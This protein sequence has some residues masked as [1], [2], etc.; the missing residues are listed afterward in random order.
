MTAVV[1]VVGG[2][3]AGIAAARELDDVAD[4]V[5]VE[6]RDAFVHNVAALRG[7]VDPVWTDRLF[8]PYDRLLVRGRVARDR[9]VR[10]DAEAVTLGS[11]ERIAAD[12]IV[13]ATGS[14][15]PF[16]AKVDVE[17]GATARARIRA[18]HDSLARSGAVLLLGAGP[19]GLELA[20]EITAMWADKT[21]TIVDPADDVVSGRFDEEFRAELRRQLD[22]LGVELVLGTSLLREPPS[23]PGEA[24][25]FTATT[26]SGREITADI[27]FRCFGVTPAT[28]YLAGELA[29]GRQANGHVRVTDQ[30]R[31]PGHDHV[32]AIG[33]ITAIPEAKMAKAAGQHAE[34]AATNIRTLIQGGEDLLA[35]RPGPPGI[36]LPLGPKGGASYAPGTGVLGAETTSRL[37][38]ADLRI[39]SY[40]ELLRLGASPDG[41]TGVPN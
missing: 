24:R 26:R 25:T 3:Y 10:V 34:V 16:P 32:F 40:L 35:Y 2:G 1:V 13:L 5:L 38:G 22:A 18:A 27:W 20:G 14:A 9:A 8:L 41:R 28:G 39:D 37:K 19:V 15:Y 11:G 33:D 4:V 21:V 29:A 31:L 12:Y 23:A 36:S 17:D 6:P 7:L 30:L